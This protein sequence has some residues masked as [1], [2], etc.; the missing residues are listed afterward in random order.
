MFPSVHQQM[1][2]GAKSITSNEMINCVM[3]DH[4]TTDMF[5]SVTSFFSHGDLLKELQKRGNRNVNGKDSLQSKMLK[6]FPL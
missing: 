1:G 3:T 4:G 5:H 6:N 2:Q